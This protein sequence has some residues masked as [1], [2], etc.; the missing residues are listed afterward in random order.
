MRGDADEIGVQVGWEAMRPVGQESSGQNGHMQR[1]RFRQPGKL[2]EG[3]QMALEI[4]GN[5]SKC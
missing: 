1:S 4:K 2:R 3:H 5:G